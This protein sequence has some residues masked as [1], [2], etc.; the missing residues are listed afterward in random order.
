VKQFGFVN[1]KAKHNSK[2][3][4]GGKFIATTWIKP[5][6]A[7]KNKNRSSQRASISQAIQYITNGAKA[8]INRNSSADEYEQFGTLAITALNEYVKNP[9]KAES[10]ELVKSY[11]CCP[12]SADIEFADSIELYEL[13]TGRLQKDNSRLIYHIRQAFKPGEIEPK[14]ANMIGYE[15]ALEFTKGEHAFVVATHTDRKHIH[16]HVIFNAVNLDCSGKFKDPWFSGKRVVA[17]IS[18]K[19]CKEYDLSV[20]EIKHGWNDPYNEWEQK[21][22]ITKE[23]REPSKRKQLEEIIALCLEKQP[24]D[25]NRLLKY[26]EDYGCIAKRRGKN[27]SISA[28]FCKNPIRINSLSNEFTEQGIKNK[29]AEMHKTAEEKT[30]MKNR[31]VENIETIDDNF[32]VKNEIHKTA[33]TTKAVFEITPPKKKELQF[34]IDIRN[35]LKATESIGYKKWAEKFNLEQMSQTLLFIEKHEL[36]LNEL[37]N[38]ANKKPQVLAEIKNEIEMVDEKLSKISTLQ[39]HIGTYGKTK[40]IYKQY[41]HA[42]NPEQ[43]K[44]ENI[45]DIADHEAAKTYFN[46]NGYGFESGNKLPTIKELREDYAKNNANKKS[47]WAKY[48]EIR[49]ADKEIDNAW[50]NVKTILNLPEDD[51]IAKTI[52]KKDAP[53][54]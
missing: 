11:E 38:M 9:I 3:L 16:N 50:Q 10:N 39:R 53:N 46:E 47:L 32:A 21:Q 54:L 23:D 49:N 24:K 13:N 51:L 2:N 25:F 40:E 42:Q 43:F 6:Y 45:K 1:I 22:G 30:R 4:R 19:L 34:I 8:N 15:L 29:I 5:T 28:P 37:E 18:D 48:H 52:P 33:K 12:E 44:Q 36:T 41:K 14:V 26:L 31:R 7:H 17:R 35:S 27:I 20:V